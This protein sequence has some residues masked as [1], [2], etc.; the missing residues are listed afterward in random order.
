MKAHVLKGTKQ[1]QQDE[2]WPG[3]FSVVGFAEGGGLRVMAAM[4]ISLACSVHNFLVNCNSATCIGAFT[5]ET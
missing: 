4:Q 1:A 2:P 5:L 3:V